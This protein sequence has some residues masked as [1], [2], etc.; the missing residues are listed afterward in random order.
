VSPGYDIFFH[1]EIP[2]ILPGERAAVGAMASLDTNGRKPFVVAR[3]EIELTGTRWVANDPVNPLLRPITARPYQLPP[4]TGGKPYTWVD[5]AVTGDECTGLFTRGAA[6]VFRDENGAVMG[7]YLD[8]ARA[9]NAALR[10][11]GDGSPQ[12]A[13]H[14]EIPATVNLADIQVRVL[15]RSRRTTG[16]IAVRDTGELTSPGS[17]DRPY[18]TPLTATRSMHERP[19]AGACGRS[20]WCY[21]PYLVRAW[22]TASAVS[23]CLA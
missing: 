6:V 13:G 16:P 5:F 9:G 23:W 10:C 4:S 17:A 21:G 3:V 7:G 19:Q 22:T 20:R 12:Q 2:V 8:T 15:R 14:G 18:W 1:Q 11:L